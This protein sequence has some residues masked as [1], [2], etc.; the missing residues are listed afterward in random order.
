MIFRGCIHRTLDAKGRL[1]F[2]VE[3]RDVLGALAPDGRCMLTTMDGCLVGM[4]WPEWEA[5]E[6]SFGRLRA[7][8][9][10]MRDFR[11]VVLGGAEPLELDPQNRLRLSKAHMGYAGLE[12]EVVLVGQ[13]SRFE[14]W[15][16]ARYRMIQEQSFDDVAEEFAESGIDIAF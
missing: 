2:P 13:V 3:F 6:A 7:P 1:M 16:S 5:F 4:P 9:R 11:R 12:R 10:K 8:S 15:D 14:L